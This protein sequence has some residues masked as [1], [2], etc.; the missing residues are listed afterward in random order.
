M[1]SCV[2]N[3][4]IIIEIYVLLTKLSACVK[5]SALRSDRRLETILNRTM[6]LSVKLKLPTEIHLSDK[7]GIPTN[8]T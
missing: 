3:D 8:P 7:F 6:E 1:I 2:G 4:N 5:Q